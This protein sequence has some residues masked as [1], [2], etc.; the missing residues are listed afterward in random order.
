M[1]IFRNFASY[2]MSWKEF[3]KILTNAGIINKIINPH[4]Q[5]NHCKF[6][7]IVSKIIS[8][9]LKMYLFHVQILHA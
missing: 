7:S 3:N 8:Q 5:V 2:M 6:Q 4:I 9:E 1:L